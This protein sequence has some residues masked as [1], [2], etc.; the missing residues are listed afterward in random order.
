MGAF[1]STPVNS[2]GCLFTDSR[3]VLAGFQPH[4][5]EKMISGFGGK[6]KG[7][8]TPLE[9]AWR[10]TLEELFEF[11]SDKSVS[12]IKEILEKINFIKTFQNKNYFVAVYSFEH[13]LQVLQI[14]QEKQLQSPLYESFPTELFELILFRKPRKS[15]E[16][17]Q[18]T[19]LPAV[20]T[21]QIDPYFLKDCSFL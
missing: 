19:L 11:P 16:V 4:K 5:K 3:H 1:Q 18:I 8:E 7:D 21:T 14:I 6:A 13:L 2:A 15:S 20:M 12:L 9:T 17:H 10:E